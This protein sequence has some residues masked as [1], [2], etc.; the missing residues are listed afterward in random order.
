MRRVAAP[1]SDDTNDSLMIE[2]W[3]GKSPTVVN[4][5]LETTGF[6][7][8]RLF[9]SFGRELRDNAALRK[10][11]CCK[12]G[13]ERTVCNVYTS[14]KFHHKELSPQRFQI[15]ISKVSSLA[16]T[17]TRREN[18]DECETGRSSEDVELKVL[19]QRFDCVKALVYYIATI[20][21]VLD[22]HLPSRVNFGSSVSDS[23][24]DLISV[25]FGPRFR[26]EG[27][28]T[29]LKVIAKIQRWRRIFRLVGARRSRETSL[30]TEHIRMLPS[31]LRVR[32][33][34]S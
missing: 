11:G 24:K 26:S 18:R 12:L 29:N 27:S 21:L 1:R 20:Y 3:S 5:D 8:V 30:D 28:G 25:S 10:S 4:G 17:R 7:F 32:A 9:W 33:R 16:N 14:K 34:V 19:L 31:F 22:F 2:F 13:S 6:F 23:W 15:T